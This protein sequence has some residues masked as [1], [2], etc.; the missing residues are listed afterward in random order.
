M[1]ME[2]SVTPYELIDEYYPVAN[3]PPHTI[4][5]TSIIARTIINYSSNIKP[6]REI[7]KIRVVKYEL[8]YL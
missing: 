5:I 1:N 7:T 4:I 3:S 8:H 2:N 6:I